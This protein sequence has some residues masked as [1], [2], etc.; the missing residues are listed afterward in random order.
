MMTT[1]LDHLIAAKEARDVVRCQLVKAIRK[2]GPV[3]QEIE[4][5]LRADDLAAVGMRTAQTAF[6]QISDSTRST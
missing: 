3:S 5:L 6:D 2:A 4:A 1:P